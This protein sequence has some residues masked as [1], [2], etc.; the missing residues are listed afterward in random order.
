M[1]VKILDIDG[2][3][4]KRAHR[5]YTPSPYAAADQYSQELARW[6]PRLGSADG[7]YIGDRDEVVSRIR[8]VIR[9]SGWASSA[10]TRLLDNV[11][12]S[13]FLFISTPDFRALGLT[14]EWAIDFAQEVEGRWKIYADDPEFY[15]DATRN[16]DFN[17]LLRLAFRQIVGDGE[18]IAL[19]PW[20]EDKPGNR[21]A[22]TIQMV[23]PDRLRNPHNTF[24]T[25]YLRGG[26]ELDEYGA[27]VAY[28]FTKSHP[29]DFYLAGSKPFEWERIER[30][31]ILPGGI[32]RRQVIHAFEGERVGQSRG[33]SP[34]I[35]VLER[36]KMVDKYDRLE[37]QAAIINAVFA[38]YIESPMDHEL[39]MEA[40]EDGT[41]TKYQQCRS[42]FHDKRG[43]TLNGVQVPTLFPGESINPVTATRP[44]SVFADFERACLRNIAAGMGLS[45]EQL[46]QDWSQVNYSSA[47]A[48]LMEVWKTLS[49]RRADFA[50]KFATPVFLLWMQEAIHRGDIKLPKGAPSFEIA[51]AAYARCNWIGQG[52]GYVDPE[53][54]AA[55]A[56]LRMN[57]MLSSL[58]DECADQGKDWR[59]VV[60]QRAR[61]NE[62]LA[63]YNLSIPQVDVHAAK[64]AASEAPK[65]QNAQQQ[66]TQ[67]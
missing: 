24:D 64:P 27:A 38:A 40:M 15:I 35:A 61:E 36:L 28:H 1:T 11:I 34:F 20:I 33:I 42:E 44:S 50:K 63:K 55:A 19:S 9:N 65:D 59:D 5:H 32:T 25:E 17:G 37:L 49:S 62:F 47:R 10:T 3:P 45:Y 18:A 53:K 57:S 52:R 46:T 23:D 16:T 13:G 30:E 22:T 2:T 29:D 67:Q 58:Q 41:L 6:N 43:L 12:G 56:N 14:P 26:V 39:L 48:A 4:M 7:D 54:E 8:D 51:K 31:V 21:Y 60:H 66:V